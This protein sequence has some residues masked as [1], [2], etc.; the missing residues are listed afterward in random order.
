ITKADIVSSQPVA[1]E[2]VV[3]SL[4]ASYPSIGPGTNN[5]SGGLAT[6]DLRGLGSNRTLV[7]F[8]GKRFVPSNLA[9]VVDTNNVPVALLD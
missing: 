4:P 8:N 2:E 6:V 9:G 7:L 1:I 3:R 5:G